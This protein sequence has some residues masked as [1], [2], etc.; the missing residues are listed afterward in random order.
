MS[1]RLTDKTREPSE[2]NIRAWLGPASLNRLE[3]LESWLSSHYD[4]NRS[5]RFPFGASYGWGYK[6]AHKQT[7][8]CYVFFEQNAFTVTLQIGDARVP[9]L[10]EHLTVLQPSTRQLWENRYPCGN[11]GGWIHLSIQNDA[12]LADAEIMIEIRKPGIISRKSMYNNS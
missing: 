6:Y 10:E 7:H 5:L 8:L 2:N 4:L 3:Q 1:T 12:D 11:R 9:A